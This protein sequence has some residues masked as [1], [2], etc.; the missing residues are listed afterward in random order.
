M[1]KMIKNL[2]KFGIGINLTMNKKL[3]SKTLIGG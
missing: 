1:M 3:T 2:D